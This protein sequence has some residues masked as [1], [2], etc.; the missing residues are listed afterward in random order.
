MDTTKHAILICGLPGSG[1]ST[2]AFKRAS[3]INDAVV[4]DDPKTWNAVVV[5]IDKCE[6]CIILTDPYLCIE[7]YRQEATHRFESHGYNVE[8]VFFD[9]NPRQCQLNALERGSKVVRCDI[10]WFSEQYVIPRGVQVL[11]VFSRI[12]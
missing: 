7:K 8:W 6:K 12:A 1:K 4:I 9:N 3:Q 11:P 5:H 10:V 2:Y